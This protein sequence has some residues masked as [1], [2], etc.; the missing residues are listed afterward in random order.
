MDARCRGVSGLR[1]HTR[2]PGD[3]GEPALA[4]ASGHGGV[5]GAG[6]DRAASNGSSCHTGATRRHGRPH[7]FGVTADGVHGNGC[8]AEPPQTAA[9]GL[10]HRFFQPGVGDQCDPLLRAADLRTRRHGREVCAP[11]IDRNRH[12]EPRVHVHRAVAHRPAWPAYAAGD[13]IAGLYRVAGAVCL[14]VRNRQLCDR[15]R[16]Y[17]RL[18]RRPRDRPGGGDLGVHRRDLSR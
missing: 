8:V 15:A 4:A 18:H 11:P 3:P 7:R 9:P 2:L 5:A 17:F 13:R 10:P 14:G 16:L 12:H 6:D 1:L